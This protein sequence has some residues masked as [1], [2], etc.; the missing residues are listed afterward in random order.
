MN[1]RINTVF[2][3]D[4]EK[5]IRE[6]IKKLL[7][8]NE[9]GCTICGEA[10]NGRDAYIRIQEQRPDIVITDL[11]MPFE[12]GISLA[13]RLAEHFPEIITIV[14]TGFDEFEYAKAAVRAGVFDF[15]LKPV[16]P[17]ELRETI[18]R[19][20]NKICNLTYP[21]PFELEAELITCIQ[22]GDATSSFSLLN[23]LFDEF[24][25]QRVELSLVQN[26]CK[27]VITEIDTC[28][29]RFIG[30]EIAIPKPKI[31]SLTS[32]EQLRDE[33]KQYVNQIFTTDAFS[34]SDLLVEKIKYY[35]ESHFQENI[36]LKL[37]ENEFFFNASYISR[38]FKSK[39]GENYNDYLLKLRIEYAKELL[40]TT[41]RSI[42]QISE[43]AGFG[44]SKY[45][46]RIFK[47]CTGITPINY[48]MTNHR[49][50]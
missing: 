44:N 30:G 41:N 7:H 27:K 26:I 5:I 22:N 4:D 9:L 37:L 1:N 25:T 46:S 32:L 21:Y 50:D 17:A 18:I 13:N 45:F 12:D 35:L 11:K 15:L 29:H 43:M 47:A 31:S 34:S 38:I 28:Y 6:G 48:R 2:I 10:A 8:W 39:T 42:L 3:V 16:S 20:K 19:A 14:V 23:R 24:F 40:S 49:K 33:M 36:T